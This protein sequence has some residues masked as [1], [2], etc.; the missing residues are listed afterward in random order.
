[1]NRHR[2]DTVLA[3]RHSS[4]PDTAVRLSDDVLLAR[5]GAGDAELAIAFVRRLEPIVFGVA[6][7]VIS[8]VK[9]YQVACKD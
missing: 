3:P 2:T 9:R 1:M 8:D 7:T 5:L 6:R 4:R